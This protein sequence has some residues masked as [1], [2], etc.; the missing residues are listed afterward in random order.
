[1]R[2]NRL[3]ASSAVKSLQKLDFSG[4]T[5]KDILRSEHLNV[6]IARKD[7]IPLTSCGNT[8]E[9]IPEKLLCHVHFVG[10][11]SKDTVTCQNISGFTW[12]IDQ[13][14]LRNN[15]SVIAAK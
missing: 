6:D 13:L 5:E 1:M 7:F 2:R 15:C 3:S 8:F 9:Y 14:S 10:N 12:K 4:I 11:V